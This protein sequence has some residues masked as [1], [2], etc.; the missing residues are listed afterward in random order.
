VRDDGDRRGTLAG[1]SDRDEIIDVAIAYTWALDTKQL[2]DLRRVF[3]PD[4]TAML[5]DVECSGLDAIV[6]RIGGA[7]MRLDQTQHFV[8]NH[9][10]EVDGDEATHRCQL[11]GQH[12]RAGTDGGDNYIVGG[13]YEDRFVRTPDGWRIAHRVMQQTWTEGNP[14]VVRR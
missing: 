1:M 13:F 3:T 5:R 9:Q 4:A 10:V 7:I 2:D 14:A 8:G 12:V 11:Q 6:D